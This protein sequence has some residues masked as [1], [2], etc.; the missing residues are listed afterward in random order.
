M[1]FPRIDGAFETIGKSGAPALLS[2][3]TERIL[4]V[5]D[6]KIL[7]DLGKQ[8]L[9]RAGYEVTTLTSSIEALER[10]SEDP[11]RFDLVVTD[12]S[13]PDMTGEKLARE[14]LNVR[15]GM[16]VIMCSGF[17][18]TARRE[19]AGELG[20]R[21]FVP[22]PLTFESLARAVREALDG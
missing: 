4:F 19:K 5:D 2:A 21:A 9:E 18:E 17:D 12:L 11:H 1:Y 14:I 16:P 15:P 3:G 10:F 8:M 22:K 6:E 13:M 7:A 20:V